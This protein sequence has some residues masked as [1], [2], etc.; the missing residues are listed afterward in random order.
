MYI[1]FSEEDK[2]YYVKQFFGYALSYMGKKIIKDFNL[3][4][5][6]SNVEN[7]TDIK[8]IHNDLSNLMVFSEHYIEDSLYYKKNIEIS[9][10]DYKE[11]SEKTKGMSRKELK[12]YYKDANIKFLD[13]SFSL[14]EPY[15]LGAKIV[16]EEKLYKF[17][18]TISNMDYGFRVIEQKIYLFENGVE[19]MY[20]FPTKSLSCIIE[21]N[22]FI[23]IEPLHGFMSDKINVEL[24]SPYIERKVE[25]NDSE[26]KEHLGIIMAR[27]REQTFND[28]IEIGLIKKK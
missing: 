5:F 10:Q 18:Y 8:E 6:K 24:K 9:N 26:G 16:S 7:I 25:K 23:H 1:Y 17:P 19:K 13:K 4:P 14:L 11:D 27:G 15:L 21:G 22:N 12:A 2:H 3:L 28:A 20:H